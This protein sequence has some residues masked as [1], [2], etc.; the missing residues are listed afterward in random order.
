MCSNYLEELLQY[1][2]AED[3]CHEKVCGGDNFIEDKLL[4]HIGANLSC[5]VFSCHVV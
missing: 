1:I 4:V 5:H 3:V 2:V